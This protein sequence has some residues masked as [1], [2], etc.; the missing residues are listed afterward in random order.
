[1]RP[2][3][4]MLDWHAC[5]IH[6]LPG[7][8]IPPCCPTVLIEKRPAARVGDL[9]FCFPPP[10]MFDVSIEG[11]FTTLIGGRPAAFLESK[12][13]HNEGKV[14]MGSPTVLLGGN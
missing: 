3:S 8:F 9:I 1:M 2:A 7:P 4:R 6:P 10:I 13:L 5:K 12:T 14:V 11:K